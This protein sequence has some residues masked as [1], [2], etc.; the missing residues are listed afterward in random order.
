MPGIARGKFDISQAEDSFKEYRDYFLEFFHAEKRDGLHE[1]E[2]MEDSDDAVLVNVTYCV[3][4][5]I[6]KLC[7]IKEACEP[8]CYSDEVFFPSFLD[9][10]GGKFIRTKTLGRG[11]DCCDFRLERKKA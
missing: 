5:E 3:F 9:Q 6:P 11:D 8:S 1:F 7:G 10:V 2:V 4:H